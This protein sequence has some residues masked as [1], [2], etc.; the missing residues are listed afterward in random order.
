MMFPS[1][2][3]FTCCHNL[4]HYLSIYLLIYNISLSLSVCACV[5]QFVCQYLSV[6]ALNCFHPI[7]SAS[8][9]IS[10][11]FLTFLSLPS[12][13][14]HC[15]PFHSL[16]IIFKISM[17][18]RSSFIAF[19]KLLFTHTSSLQRTIFC[20]LHFPPIRHFFIALH[21]FPFPSFLSYT[22]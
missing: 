10:L 20:S 2:T 5:C 13:H 14:L 16:W 6:S 18:F 3:A 22:K 15:F 12:F 21:N 19:Y 7:L 17:I 4:N 9:N 1:K 11:I 8:F